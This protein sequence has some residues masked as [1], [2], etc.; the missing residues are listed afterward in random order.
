MTLYWIAKGS[1]T[2]HGPCVR[3][4]TT[5]QRGLG[6]QLRPRAIHGDSS[7][8]G[9]N[10]LQVVCTICRTSTAKLFSALETIDSHDAVVDVKK[11]VSRLEL[12]DVLIKV[13]ACVD[14]VHEGKRTC[15]ETKVNETAKIVV[16]N[17]LRTVLMRQPRSQKVFLVS[18][19]KYGFQHVLVFVHKSSFHLTIWNIFGP[20]GLPLSCNWETLYI[21][22]AKNF[23][24]WNTWVGSSANGIGSVVR[25]SVR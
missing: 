23:V 19:M 14:G 10:Y 15:T 20:V 1:D 9:L 21:L 6:E 12:H 25:R 17:C 4:I 24:N 16:L 3:A 7:D 13:E 22:W 8:E 18:Q 5:V 11:L 2:S